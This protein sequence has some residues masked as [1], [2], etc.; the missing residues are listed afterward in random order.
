MTQNAWDTP[1]LTTDG[2][3]LIGNGSARPTAGLIT[4]GTNVTINAG[5]GT[6]EIETAPIDDFVVVQRDTASNTSG[7]D[8]T[9]GISNYQLLMLI[10]NDTQP[11]TSSGLGI[12]ISTDGGSTFDTTAA[13]YSG[14]G[15]VVNSNSVTS[16]I[17][18]DETAGGKL[19]I[20]SST[21]FTAGSDS[22]ETSS[23]VCYI[24]KPS[25]A[26][27]TKTSCY[28]AYIDADGDHVIQWVGGLHKG[29]AAVNALRLR[30]TTG[31]IGSGE[32]VMYGA[33][34]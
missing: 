12:S 4:E 1:Y 28:C 19:Q 34:T 23:F 17:S 13:N 7:I 15:W 24:F 29:T 25:G 2:H 8:Y 11:A 16:N 14:V 6:C 10:G 32:F 31:N 3:L 20:Y 5:A 30:Q 27:W 18:S 22:N 26:L 33:V 21:E 9:C